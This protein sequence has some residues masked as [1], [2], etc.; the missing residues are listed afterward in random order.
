MLFRSFNGNNFDLPLISAALAGANNAKLK[1]FSDKIIKN[2]AKPWTLK[3][4]GNDWDHIDL[5]EISPG[6]ASLKIYGGRMHCPKMQDLP[7]DPDQDISPEQRALLRHYCANDLYTT[8]ALFDK[9]TPQIKLR[10]QMSAQYGIDLRSKSDAQIA[11][12]VICHEVERAGVLLTKEDPFRLAG[13]TFK[14]DPPSFLAFSSPELQA[15]LEIGRAH[16]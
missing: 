16:V 6:I 1:E 4:P 3:I 12:A 13:N 8:Q 14:Y 15:V 5:I 2:N 11:E 9:L 7:I 10:E